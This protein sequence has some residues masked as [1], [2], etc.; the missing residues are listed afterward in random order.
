MKQRFENMSINGR[1]AYVI[2]CVEVWLQGKYPDR[3][4]TI[5]SE[6]MWKATE[7]NWGD[8]LEIY[9]GYIP[10]VLFSYEEYGE[11]LPESFSEDIYNR[12]RELYF[13]ITS[14]S[15][16]N[17]EDSLDYMLT[18]PHEMAMVYEGTG[19]GDG[20]ESLEIIEDVERVLSNSCI[21][22]PDYHRVHFS[23]YSQLHGWGNNFDGR[24]LSIVLNK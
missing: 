19:I 3:D 12:L 8:W 22:L 4:W 13:G 2:M 15:E 1:M 7:M 6:T 5:V 14:G 9:A 24:F 11:D 18:K 23:D 21:P 16:D 10:H 17:P 20:H